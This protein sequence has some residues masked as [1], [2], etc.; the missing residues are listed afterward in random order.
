MRV[1]WSPRRR[2][3]SP[4]RALATVRS[5]SMSANEPS[6]PRNAVS[7]RGSLSTAERAAVPCS[8]TPASTWLTAGT[9]AET[10]SFMIVGVNSFCAKNGAGAADPSS[11]IHSGTR[12]RRDFNLE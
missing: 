1:T 6:S 8:P 12:A 2:T 10:S 5:K 4:L 11:C 3:S 9:S 7:L